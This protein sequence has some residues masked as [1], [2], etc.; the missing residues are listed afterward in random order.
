MIKGMDDILSAASDASREQL[1][2]VTKT[3]KQVELVGEENLFANTV[4]WD[5]AKPYASKEAKDWTNRDLLAYAFDVYRSKTGQCM[6]IAYR[7]AQEEVLKLQEGMKR[8]FHEWPS[9]K[10]TKLYIDWFYNE[11]FEMLLSTYGR[12][13]MKMMRHDIQLSTFKDFINDNQISIKSKTKTDSNDIADS[14]EEMRELID[15]NL[16]HFLERYGLFVCYQ[17]LRK[18][19]RLSSIGCLQRLS[20]PTMELVAAKKTDSLIDVTEGYG[21]YPEAM[22]GE[23]EELTTALSKSSGASFS[24]ISVEYSNAAQRFPFLS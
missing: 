7:S 20:S 24:L 16:S 19:E 4:G 21:P 3:I 1:G 11:P 15:S 22:K 8:F 2:K 9:P 5:K 13:T 12:V 23:F 10:F 6:N 17:W 18:I 14:Q